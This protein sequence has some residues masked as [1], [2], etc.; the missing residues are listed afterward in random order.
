VNPYILKKTALP[1]VAE[2]TDG[3]VM[4]KRMDIDTEGQL[5]LLLN[6]M[7]TAMSVK[8]TNMFYA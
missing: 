1:M 6:N 3:G 7:L 8:K 5:H 2:L 4:P